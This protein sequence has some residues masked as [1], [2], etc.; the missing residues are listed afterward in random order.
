[1][2][3]GIFRQRWVHLLCFPFPTAKLSTIAKKSDAAKAGEEKGRIM[4]K[5]R[6]YEPTK[7]LFSYQYKGISKT[8][9]NNRN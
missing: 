1:M 9:E 5:K 3:S 6:I 2:T 8:L 7:M 4:L